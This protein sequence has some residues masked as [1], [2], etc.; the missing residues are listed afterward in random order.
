V[1]RQHPAQL[2]VALFGLGETGSPSDASMIASFISHDT[3]RVRVAAVSALRRLCPADW[4]ASFVTA[5]QD[6]SPK[7]S[8]AAQGAL[9]GVRE[10]LALGDLWSIFTSTP[11]AHVQRHVLALIADWS[12]WDSIAYLLNAVGN[13]DQHL[14]QQAHWCLRRWLA[15]LNRDFTQ[16]TSGQLAA[17]RRAF[18]HKS[19]FLDPPVRD[20]LSFILR[21]TSA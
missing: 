7:V 11:T 13:P 9:R 10:Q 12:K 3:V 6:P 2:A 4:A 16:P 15:R 14:D 20:E 17:F 21:T 19:S 18:M 5:L 8:R 1:S